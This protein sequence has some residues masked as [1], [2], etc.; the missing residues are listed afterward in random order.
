MGGSGAHEFMVVNGFG[1]DVLVLCE[2]C[3][4]ADNQQIAVV[5][6]AR[7]GAPRTSC[8]WRTS[9]RRARRR[10][11]RSAAFLGDPEVEDGQGGLLRH[12]RWAL[13]GRD[14]PRRLRR[15]RDEARQPPQGDRRTPAGDGRGD[16]GARHGGGLRLA[17]RR[18]RRRRRRRRAGRPLAEPRRGRQPGGL[19]RPERERAAATTR[20][21]T[22]PRSR[23]PARAIPA[24]SAARR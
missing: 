2:T 20:R 17:D 9:R 13:R 22:S 12:R 7:S 10:S 24:R 21:T 3:G 5:R 14:R 18:P 6:Q 19:A 4:F 23:T 11:T 16:Q 8:R 15:Q 1:E